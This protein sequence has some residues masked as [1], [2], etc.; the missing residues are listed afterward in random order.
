MV[1][2]S[3]RVRRESGIDDIQ[4]DVDLTATADELEDEDIDA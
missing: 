4:A 2:I 1:E 3:E